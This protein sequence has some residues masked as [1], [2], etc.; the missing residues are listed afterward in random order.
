MRT[1]SNNNCEK[2]HSARGFCRYHYNAWY[3]SNTN[4][5]KHKLKT[6]IAPGST[7]LG[8]DTAPKATKNPDTKDLYW[9]AGFL[10]GEGSFRGG[11]GDSKVVAAQV[12]K[13]PLERLKTLFGGSLYLE[14]K[15]NKNSKHKDIWWWKTYGARAR[16]IMMTLYSLMSPR[17][18]AQIKSALGVS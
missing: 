17:R 8:K 2:Q 18:Q 9:A 1:C 10:E 13:E 4:G 14:L 15:N 11:E 16:G 12:Q 6:P 5:R 3:R 7:V